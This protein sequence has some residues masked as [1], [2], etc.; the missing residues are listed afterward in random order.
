M[1]LP[2]FFGF[3]GKGWRN[4]Q[5]GPASCLCI[6]HSSTINHFPL[7]HGRVRHSCQ[8]SEDVDLKGVAERARELDRNLEDRKLSRIR[9]RNHAQQ[10]PSDRKPRRAMKGKVSARGSGLGLGHIRQFRPTLATPACGT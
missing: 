2:G 7:R 6:I 5:P 8:K 1:N 3:G 10:L 4:D 9:L